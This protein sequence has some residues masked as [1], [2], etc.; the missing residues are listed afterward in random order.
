MTKCLTSRPPLPARSH[1]RHISSHTDCSMVCVFISQLSCCR[2]LRVHCRW[3]VGSECVCQHTLVGSISKAFCRVTAEL[4]KAA[5]LCVFI[6][7]TGYLYL[8]VLKRVF[9]YRCAVYTYSSLSRLRV[10]PLA[11]SWIRL[12]HRH[13]FTQI[14]Y[15]CI[16]MVCVPF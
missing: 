8:G 7:G 14:T 11:S 3:P 1:H 5:Q 4:G 9:G 10:V 13:I 16:C 12:P 2:F 15:T 6:L